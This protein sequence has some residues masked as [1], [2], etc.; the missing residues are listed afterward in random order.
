MVPNYVLDCM[1]AYTLVEDGEAKDSICWGR[2]S[3]GNFSVS[4]AYNV[5][6]FSAGAENDEKWESIWRIITTTRIKVF[7]W[8]ARHQ[9]FMSNDE[10]KLVK[11]THNDSC[12]ICPRIMEDANHILRCYPKAELVWKSWL[13]NVLQSKYG[14]DRSSNGGMAIFATRI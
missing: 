8:L 2:E 9:K 12:Y 7:V 13:Q 1:E 5:V 11:F 3:S 10:R 14:V 6:H 4:S